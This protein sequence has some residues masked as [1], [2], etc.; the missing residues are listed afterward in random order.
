MVDLFAEQRLIRP[1][2]VVLSRSSGAEHQ[3]D[4]LY[5]LGSQPL[6]ALGDDAVVALYRKG[7]VAAASILR[8][9]LSQMERLWQL[10]QAASLE[11]WKSLDVRVLES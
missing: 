6:A 9:S 1:L 7:Y 5:S 3:L 8:A 11:P 2:S 10:H 4:G